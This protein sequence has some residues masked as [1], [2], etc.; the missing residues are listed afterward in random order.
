M[1]VFV[2]MTLRKSWTDSPAFRAVA[3]LIKLEFILKY[4]T[5][6]TSLSA[7]LSGRVVVSPDTVLF[8]RPR[9]PFVAAWQHARRASTRTANTRRHPT[10]TFIS[11]FK[12]FCKYISNIRRKR[13][14]SNCWTLEILKK[15]TV[16][17]IN[18]LE[19]AVLLSTAFYSEWPD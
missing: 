19:V 8:H 4:H 18:R 7:W 16:Y 10:T 5:L 9:H 14:P 2:K 13:H 17:T 1:S 12:V 15:N 6:V 3:K 11:G